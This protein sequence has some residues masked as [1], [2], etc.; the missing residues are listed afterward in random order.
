MAG[1]QTAEITGA[2]QGGQPR[3]FWAVLRYILPQGLCT[4]GPSTW[5]TLHLSLPSPLL[6]PAFCLS[7]ILTSI[8]LFLK[9]HLLTEIFLG[10]S[11]H[12]FHSPALLSPPLCLFPS[13]LLITT[14]L[15]I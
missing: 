10:H 5:I 12:Y 1:S 7:G 8:R 9:H 13:L 2:A 15:C 4:G 3:C 11:I 14:T 6:P